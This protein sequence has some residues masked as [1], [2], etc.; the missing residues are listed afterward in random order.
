MVNRVAYRLRGGIGGQVRNVSAEPVAVSTL[1]DIRDIELSIGGMTCAACA[2]RVEK[3]LN[4]VGPEVI[5]AVNVATSRAMIAAPATVS[6][7]ALITAVQNA[8]Y[9]AQVV[10]AVP[11]PAQDGQAQG[12]QAQD[13]QAQ[14]GPAQDGP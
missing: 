6:P 11:G 9:S 5:S 2:A 4:A 7:H 8:G 14:D 3:K 12:D 13:G 10:P 1:T